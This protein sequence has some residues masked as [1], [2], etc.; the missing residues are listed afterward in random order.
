MKLSGGLAAVQGAG[1]VAVEHDGR[2]TSI[3]LHWRESDS[4]SRCRGQA[5]PLLRKTRP[6]EC[7]RAAADTLKGYNCCVCRWTKVSY[8][9]NVRVRIVPRE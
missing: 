4:S 7:C 3:S 2:P 1:M 6:T 9:L 5:M 8:A